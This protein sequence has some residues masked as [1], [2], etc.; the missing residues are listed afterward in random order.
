MPRSEIPV[1]VLWLILGFV[2]KADL[3]TI[4]QL[5][6]IY[7]ACSQDILYRDIIVQNRRVCQ[8]LAQSTHLARRVRSFSTRDMTQELAKA[9]QNMTSLRSLTLYFGGWG[10]SSVL[11]G[12]TFKLDTFR[13]DLSYDESLCNF[14]DGQPSLMRLEFLEYNTGQS[15][16]GRLPG[17]T[18]VTAWFAMLPYLIPGRPVSAVT[19][20]GPPSDRDADLIFFTLSTAPIEKL[21]M[22][23]SCLYP[24]PARLLASVFPSLTHLTVHEYVSWTVMPTVRCP[25]FN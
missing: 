1:D 21:T 7:C 13:C 3:P 23:L 9:L 5:N 22:D 4:C 25:P 11:D 6:K 16:E 17:L 14:L 12:C 2:D 8:T 20:I 10:S 15:F 24:K 19:S 18:R